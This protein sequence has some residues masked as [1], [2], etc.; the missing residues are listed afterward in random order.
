M[1]NWRF[2]RR[3]FPLTRR[4][5]HSRVE[6]IPIANIDILLRS[7]INVM[8][9]IRPTDDFDAILATR[10]YYAVM[11]LKRFFPEWGINMQ[12][13]HLRSTSPFSENR[14]PPDI[15]RGLSD[16]DNY[17]ETEPLITEV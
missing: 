14:N 1:N 4:E 3:T 10:L 5:A 13:H 16:V 6:A 15:N 2:R 12:P 11:C 7:I 9:E 17:S 8:N